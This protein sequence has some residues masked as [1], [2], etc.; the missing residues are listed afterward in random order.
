MSDE[1][2]VG[3]RTSAV[4]PAPPKPAITVHSTVSL[5]ST[6]EI[7]WQDFEEWLRSRGVE[8]EDM[9][10]AHIEAQGAPGKDGPHTIRLTFKG[11]RQD[12]RELR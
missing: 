3:Y 10:L 7:P 11:M 4:A 2:P 12:R 5:T 9:S 1:K 8:T 6:V